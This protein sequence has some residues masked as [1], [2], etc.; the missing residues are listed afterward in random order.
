VSFGPLIF[1]TVMF[2]DEIKVKPGEPFALGFDL[3]SVAGV[4][5]AEL[6]QDGR[7]QKTESFRAATQQIHVDFP[8]STRRPTW[9]ALIVEDYEGHK[10]YTD[11]IWV[12]AVEHLQ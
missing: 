3:K 10:A 6:I 8:L 9:Y 12:D 7:V 11:P 5:Q 4:K 2:G 1:P